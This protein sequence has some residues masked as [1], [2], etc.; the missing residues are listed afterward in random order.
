M[1]PVSFKHLIL[2]SLKASVQTDLLDLSPL[3]ITAL[4]NS[5]LE[6][7]CAKRFDYFN[8]VQTQIFH[9]LYHTQ[10]NALIGAPTG[11]GKTVAAELAIW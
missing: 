1:I 10:H 3:P 5:S 2:P 4:Q 8:A 7:I 9:T 6:D 11:S